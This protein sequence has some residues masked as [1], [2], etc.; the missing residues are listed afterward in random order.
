M[1][2]YSII[3]F[4]L[5]V[6]FSNAQSVQS[7]SKEIKLDFKLAENGKPTYS[8][9]YKNKPIVLQSNL[10]IKLKE[11]DDLASGFSIDSV[12]QKSINETWQP[13]L[14][15]QSNIKNNYNL[16]IVALS[17]KSTNRKINIIFKIYDEGVAFCYDNFGVSNFY[18]KKHLMA[19]EYFEKGL[20][21]FT[22]INNYEIGRAHV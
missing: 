13:V 5:L 7:P 3:L 21:I 6:F 18:Q 17:Q 11:G 2:N 19:I 10:G 14:G 12:G 16:M 1:K 20:K 9:T 8:V 15:E 22:K 4:L